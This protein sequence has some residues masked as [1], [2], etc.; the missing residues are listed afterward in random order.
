MTLSPT[1]SS[2]LS[3][4][5]AATKLNLLSKQLQKDARRLHD[6]VMRDDNNNKNRTTRSGGIMNDSNFTTDQAFYGFS[7][8]P[9]MNFS[10][11]VT[12]TSAHSSDTSRLRKGLEKSMAATAAL[13]EA[14]EGARSAMDSLQRESQTLFAGIEDH[15]S[16]THQ[17]F[18]SKWQQQEADIAA[19]AEDLSRTLDNAMKTI[20]D[21]DDEIQ[22]LKEELRRE[23]DK[24]KVLEDEKLK[25]QAK[26]LECVRRAMRMS[27]EKEQEVV[28]LR[29]E[30]QLLKIQIQK[31]KIGSKSILKSTTSPSK[32]SHMNDN[33]SSISP[34]YDMVSPP[35]LSTYE[36]NHSDSIRNKEYKASPSRVDTTSGHNDTYSVGNQDESQSHMLLKSMS[37]PAQLNPP[38]VTDTHRELL[39][40]DI[41]MSGEDIAT[42]NDI[43]S[44][45]N[46]SYTGN[47][48]DP[49]F[50]IDDTSSLLAKLEESRSKRAAAVN[51]ARKIN[52]RR[53]SLVGEIRRSTV[54]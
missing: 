29:E 9:M 30:I 48:Q 41:K 20:E 7:S 31:E 12:A 15:V 52:R 39:L 11:G 40:G 36:W 2:M 33:S 44:V 10:N 46:D 25:E 51:K 49:E 13:M 3:P 38:A 16:S 32:H 42:T 6:N 18:T 37:L 23:K 14:C 43:N 5:G 4:L 19:I 35:S 47:D 27:G 34:T 50:S 1:Q 54:S 45:N 21:R 53:S 22:M 17:E 28:Q 8:S 26:E 24:S